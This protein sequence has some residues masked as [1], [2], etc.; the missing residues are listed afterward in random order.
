MSAGISSVQLTATP[1][2]ECASTTQPQT[3]LIQD[4]YQKGRDS[5]GNSF[6]ESRNFLLGSL[7]TQMIQMG[8]A[9]QTMT[10]GTDADYRGSVD[11]ILLS[12]DK[13]SL[14]QKTFEKNF[15]PEQ[16]L[17]LAQTLRWL[18]H[19]YQNIDTFKAISNENN[20]RFNFLYGSAEELLK[21]DNSESS[22]LELAELYYNTGFFMHLREKQGDYLGACETYEKALGLNPSEAMQARVRNMRSR[23]RDAAGIKTTPE[24]FK[25]DVLEAYLKVPTDQQ[26]PFLIAM[27]YNN[28]AK[29]IICQSEPDLAVAEEALAHTVAYMEKAERGEVESHAYFGGFYRNVAELKLMQ[30][31]TVGALEAYAKAAELDSRNPDSYKA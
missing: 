27:Y 8:F 25:N 3:Q 13:T 5:Y 6:D 1:Y 20:D 11:P 4:L 14:V 29:M 19:C 10:P 12:S 28:Y 30:K 26:D 16:R 18:G 2:V 7:Y 9:S 23:L 22:K 24:E 15:T 31:N 21:L 17:F